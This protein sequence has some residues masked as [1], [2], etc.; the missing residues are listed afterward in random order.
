MTTDAVR[1]AAI[2]DAAEARDINFH[3]AG[4]G[5]IGI[6][7]NETTTLADLVEILE[8][9]ASAAGKKGAV[10]LAGARRSA[11]GPARAAEAHQRVPVA[12]GVQRP[13]L[14]DRDD[15]LHPQPRAQGHR[16]RHVDDPARLLH[17]EAERRQ[18]DVS[19]VVAG[20]LAH[21]PV[22]TRQPDRRLPAGVR[23]A[24]GRALR[25][26][27]LCRRVAAAQ[28]RRAGRVRRPGRHSRLSPGAR[29]PAPR[30][31]P[32]SRVRA[33]HQPGQRD[34]GRFPRRRRRH[35]ARMATSTWRT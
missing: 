20:V 25:G 18:R 15:A 6:A 16:A 2:H 28:L 30:R 17:D 4:D 23:R 32:D 29:R 3:R 34:H 5:A 13:S 31:R 24:G 21:A 1:A 10:V 14:G 22:R 7:L 19:G 27:R 26:D 33:R 35:R 8:L 12:P 9:F 11:G